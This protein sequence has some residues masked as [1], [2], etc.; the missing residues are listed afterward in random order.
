MLLKSKPVHQNRII[1]YSVK[2]FHGIENKFSRKNQFENIKIDINF[3]ELEK[4]KKDRNKALY[5]KKLVNP[6]KVKINLLFQGKEYK[7][8][9]RLK[10]DLSEH[11]GN[12]KQ[13]SLRI[14]LDKNKLF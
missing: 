13:W 14:K 4:L 8:T 7:A 6:Q 12:L 1:D 9:A 10:G 3:S 2:L 5:L 11:W